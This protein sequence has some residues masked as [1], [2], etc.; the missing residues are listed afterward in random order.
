[1]KFREV[2]DSTRDTLQAGESWQWNPEVPL[3]N[4]K[5]NSV[6]PKVCT[7]LRPGWSRRLGHPDYRGRLS[8]REGKQFVEKPQ[9]QGKQVPRWGGAR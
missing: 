5:V 2:Y 8:R 7:P 4:S 3:S 6:V 1:M 9:N